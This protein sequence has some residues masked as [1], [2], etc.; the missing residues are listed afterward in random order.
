[1]QETRIERMERGWTCHDIGP[2]K[3]QDDWNQKRSDKMEVRLFLRAE[4]GC[5]NLKETSSHFMSLFVSAPP[6][7][8]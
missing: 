1:M 3:I 5:S 8:L 4:R 6:D 7:C 2:G